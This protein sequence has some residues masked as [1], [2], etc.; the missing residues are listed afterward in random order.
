MNPKMTDAEL[1]KLMAIEA[2][3]WHLEPRAIGTEGWCTSDGKWLIH[4]T[5]WHPTADLNQ[6]LEA[7]DGWAGYWSMFHFKGKTYDIAVSLSDD[8]TSKIYNTYNNSLARAICKA[9]LMAVRGE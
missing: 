8:Y 1:D 3:G 5:A 7:L 2:M 6:A 9:V 4:E